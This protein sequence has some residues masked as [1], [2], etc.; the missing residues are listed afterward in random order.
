MRCDR[1]PPEARQRPADLP[2]LPQRMAR[3]ARRGGV[4][5]RRRHRP[6]Q[7]DG[8]RVRG[9]R[10]RGRRRQPDELQMHRLRRRGHDQH[11]QR[12]DGA[13]PLVPACLRRQRAGRQWRGA[14]CRA[15]LS[16]QEGRCGRTN[17]PVRRQ[18]A[19]VRPEGVQGAVHAGERDRRLPAVHDRRWQCQRRHRRPWRDQDP[20]IHQG[21][22]RQQENLLRCRRLPG[23]TACRL[24]RRRSAAGIL[25][26]SRQPRYP[27]QH[28]QHHQHDPALRHQERGQVERVL[29]VGLQLG[30]A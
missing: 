8:Y 29:L 14:R 28:Q 24:H 21:Q 12:D 2:V 30:K 27:Q 23:T 10:H 5:P 25:Q 3:A 4:R 13:L 18:A 6:A 22:R 11:C 20:R 17:P 1:H 9:A 16:H 19:P 15:A 7:G 26:R